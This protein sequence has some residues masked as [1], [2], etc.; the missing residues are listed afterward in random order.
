MV[1]NILFAPQ[2]RVTVQLIR[3]GMFML[4]FSFVWECLCFSSHTITVMTDLVAAVGGRVGR[5][6]D[7]S[8]LASCFGLNVWMS[9]HLQMFPLFSFSRPRQELP[10]NRD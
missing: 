10:G 7:V 3:L 8:S 4:P 1:L 6:Y 9:S 2:S 5:L